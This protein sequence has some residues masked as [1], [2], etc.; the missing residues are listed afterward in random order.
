MNTM[1]IDIGTSGCKAIVCDAQGRQLAEAHRQYA[2][3]SPEAGAAELDSEAVMTA[4]FEVIRMAAEAAGRGSVA[5]LGVSS[6]GEAFTAVG[7]DGK[8]LC[9]A[10]VSSDVR[11]THHAETWPQTFG[12]KRLYE[13]TGHTAHPMFTLFKLLW[14]RDNRPAVWRDAARFLCFEDLLSLRL[15]LEPT[16]GWPLAGRTMLFDVR[17]H[18]WNADILAAVGLDGSRLAR[19]MPSGKVTGILSAA[20]ARDLA[21]APGACVVTGGHDQPCAALGAGAIAPGTAMYATGTV[22]CITPAFARAIFSEGQRAGNLCTYDHTMPGHYATV[23]FSLTGGNLLTWVRDRFGADGAAEADRTGRSAY[24]LLIEEAGEGPSP[25]LA[26]PYWTPSGTP[27]FDTRTPGLVTGWRM[28]TTRGQ[29]IRALL[30]GVAFEMR[31]NLRILADAGCPIHQLNAVG[32]GARSRR[33]TQLKADVIGRPVHVMEV[34]EAGCLG[35]ALLARAALDHA[36]I[37]ELVRAWVRVIDV[38]EPNPQRAPLFAER[39]A[40]YQ[41]LYAAARSLCTAAP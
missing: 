14:L 39:F 33:W 19:P 27:H 17:R 15:G 29:F 37:E 6:Q 10:M 16:M 11:A 34:S 4:C 28:D 26:L 24:E 22:E 1:G 35:V 2:L 23:A 36:S 5:A 21:L 20:M 13:I 30:E 8:A 32:G 18:E 38:A 40:D 25:L 41:R 12:A 7:A 31:L 9:H 3:L